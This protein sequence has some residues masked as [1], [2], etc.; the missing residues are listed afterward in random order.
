[1][2]PA[3]GISAL[4]VLT[5]LGTACFGRAP[6]PGKNFRAASVQG[7]VQFRRSATAPW[8]PVLE[9]LRIAPGAEVKTGKD[10]AIALARDDGAR[11]DLGASSVAVLRSVRR[12]TLDA[13]RALATVDRVALTIESSGVEA[14]GKRSV[15]RVDRGFAV[16]VGVYGGEVVVTEDA[17]RATVPQLRQIEVAGGIVPRDAAPLKFSPTDPWDRQLLADVIDLDRELRTFGRAFKANFA[18]RAASPAFYASLI[19]EVPAATFSALIARTGDPADVLFG[20]VMA[21][22]LRGAASSILASLL[23]LR[24]AGAT[25][26]LIAKIMGVSF[27]DYINSVIATT[28]PGASPSPGST[29]PGGRP[30]G[31]PR[32][33]TSGS[34]RPT[35]SPSPRPTHSPTGSPSPSPSPCSDVDRLLGQCPSPTPGPIPTG[36]LGL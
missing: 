8:V 23:N 24:L 6:N 19:P 36:G 14:H 3:R 27:R 16:R 11:V 17:D 34:P 32:P 9:G 21:K 18:A 31:S 28:V 30:T 2:K 29:G 15:F 22:R 12:V 10:G 35:N 25:W 7:D 1:M 4:V 26:G 20:V 5:L 13:G 33:T